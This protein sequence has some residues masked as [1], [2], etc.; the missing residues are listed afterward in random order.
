MMSIRLKG[1]P[2]YDWLALL[3]VVLVVTSIVLATLHGIA[4]NSGLTQGIH[5]AGQQIAAVVRWIAEFFT[6]IVNWFA[7]W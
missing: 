2:W 7:S 5:R 1:M 4:P 6:M 3:V